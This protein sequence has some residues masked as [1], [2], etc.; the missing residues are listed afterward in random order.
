MKPWRR[1]WCPSTCWD[2]R[3]VP[4]S[5]ECFPVVL[6]PQ[7]ERWHPKIATNQLTQSPN[8]RIIRPTIRLSC[9]H[10]SFHGVQSRLRQGNQPVDAHC[11]PLLGWS[12]WFVSFDCR[13]GL[14][15]GYL[16]AG[17]AWE[18]DEYLDISDLVWAKV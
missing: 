2:M 12:V 7:R 16:Q 8:E 15:R 9:Q 1:S 3:L 14:H 13:L 18:G 5:C 4:W 6:G 17:P 10:L 11:I